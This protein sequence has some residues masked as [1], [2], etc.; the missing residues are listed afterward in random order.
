MGRK[1]GIAITTFRCAG[2]KNDC[3]KI[4][5]KKYEVPKS[6]NGTEQFSPFVFYHFGLIF[7]R[8]GSRKPISMTAI[9]DRKR[10]ITLKNWQPI[11]CHTGVHGYK[12]I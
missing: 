11:I 9:E 7:V 10:T 4:G 3:D 1:S 5:E 8:K 2:E 12:L 6:T